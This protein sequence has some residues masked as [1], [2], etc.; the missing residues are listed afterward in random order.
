MVGPSRD[1][2]GIGVAPGTRFHEPGSGSY[3]VRRVLGR[4]EGC[5]VVLCTAGERTVVAELWRVDSHAARHDAAIRTRVL[6]TAVHPRMP[7]LQEVFLSRVHAGRPAITAFVF[8]A[9]PGIPVRVLFQRLAAVASRTK[10]LFVFEVTRQLTELSAAVEVARLEL[11]WETLPDLQRVLVGPQGVFVTTFTERSGSGGAAAHPGALSV[12][13]IARCAMSLASEF[14]SVA[15]SS[16]YQHPHDAL[17][18]LEAIASGRE[19][20]PRAMDLLSWISACVPRYER[21]RFADLAV[22]RARAVQEDTAPTVQGR[23]PVPTHRFSPPRAAAAPPPAT[24]A[25][26]P[27]LAGG[28][29]V[30]GARPRASLLPR[31]ATL[32]LALFV[33]GRAPSDDSSPSWRRATQRRARVASTL[34]GRG[35]TYASTPQKDA[36]ATA[37]RRCI[38]LRSSPAGRRVFVDG[39]VLGETPLVLTLPCGKHLLQVGS[40]SSPSVIHVPCA[41]GVAAE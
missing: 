21:Q 11:S 39:R 2:S 22:R 3:R 23:R 13:A 18:R 25:G 4:G 6:R 33:C 5:A 36:S 10:L 19:P 20:A 26:P 30:S 15:A 16:A 7:A 27:A 8:E 12:Q 38:D 9:P 41:A 31:A 17:A 24:W 37:C 1:E 32:A 34:G 14:A 35:A 40:R 29:A 28:S